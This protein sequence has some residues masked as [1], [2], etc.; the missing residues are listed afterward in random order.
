MD[1]GW[2]VRGAVVRELVR[3]AWRLRQEAGTRLRFCDAIRILSQAGVHYLNA[4]IDIGAKDSGLTL[5][6]A[7]GAAGKVTVSGGLL[8][9]PKWTK[10]TRGDQ[11]A[12]IWVTHRAA[13]FWER[14]PP[15]PS[16]C[17]ADD[18]NARQRASSPDLGREL[19]KWNSSADTGRTPC[20]DTDPVIAAASGYPGDGRTRAQGRGRAA[21]PDDTRAAPA[22]HARARAE[23]RPDAGRR[24]LHA[25]LAQPRGAPLRLSSA[26]A[27]GVSGSIARGGSKLNCTTHGSVMSLG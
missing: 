24:A 9:T 7:A 19:Y 17:R 2:T 1:W 10:S 15:A 25:L 20:P 27:M 11:S 22:R 13:V 16:N 18:R 12:N 4:T 14:G 21:R 8:L 5:T 3:A 26:N 6:A 23:C